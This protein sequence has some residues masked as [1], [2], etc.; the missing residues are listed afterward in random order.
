MSLSSA[1]PIQAARPGRS[2]PRS[3]S[4]PRFFTRVVG[5]SATWP[6]TP[7]AV[8]GLSSGGAPDCGTDR[9]A[10]S[11]RTIGTAVVR[12]GPSHGCGRG[13]WAGGCRGG[14]GG[15]WPVGCARTGWA[16]LGGVMTGIDSV[17]GGSMPTVPVWWPISKVI[18]GPSGLPMLMV[19]PSSMS[20]SGTRWPLT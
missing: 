8:G 2:V 20:T 18:R 11:G 3:E 1:R 15:D 13:G 10:A 16:S 7:I 9:V 17:V 4:G 12:C 19:W 14:A 6:L 5:N